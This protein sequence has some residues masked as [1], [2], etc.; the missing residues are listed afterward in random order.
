MGPNRLIN[1]TSDAQLAID[2]TQTSGTS[3]PVTFTMNL[4]PIPTI[5]PNA[6]NG[7][8]MYLTI[9]RTGGVD[10]NEH[11]TQIVGEDT[12]GGGTYIDMYIRP[13]K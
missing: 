3:T 2:D 13:E 12:I 11:E 7:D 4:V 10:P 5:V 9:E 8:E 1:P 6:G